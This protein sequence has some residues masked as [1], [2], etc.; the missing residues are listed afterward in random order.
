ML[1]CSKGCTMLTLSIKAPHTHKACLGL[2]ACQGSTSSQSWARNCN[3]VQR[4]IGFRGPDEHYLNAL[5]IPVHSF[6]TR[7]E[8]LSLQSAEF[9]AIWIWEVGTWKPLQQLQSHGLSVTQMAFSPTGSHLI[10]VSRDRS[11]AVWLRC[12]GI[13]AILKWFVFTL[14]HGITQCKA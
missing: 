3:Y 11:L 12:A 9:A 8:M 10:S 14:T 2:R 6:F 7:L 1:G 4:K 13:K 5:T